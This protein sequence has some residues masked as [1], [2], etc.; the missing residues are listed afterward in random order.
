MITTSP[1]PADI[2][3]RPPAQ[4]MNLAAM[5]ASHATRLSFMRILLRRL[6]REKWRFERRVFDI[7]ARGVGTAVYVA[8]GPQCSYSLVCFGHDLP[9]EMRSDRVI[10]TAW[11]ATF[12]LHDGIA[13][14]QTIARLRDNIPL[15]EAG[16]VLA[17]EL[18]VSR[19]NRSVRL[20]EHVV[21]SLASGRQPNGSRVTETGYLMRTTAVYG[22]GKL[23]AADRESIAE[24]PEFNAPFQ[25]EMLSVYL[26]RA[27][28]ADLV[29]QM[30]RLRSPKTAVPLEPGLR[31]SLGVGNS[32]GLGMAPFLV[33]HP[34]LLNNWISAREHALARVRNLPAASAA[35][36]ARFLDLLRSSRT[37]ALQWHS[38]DPRQMQC[39]EGLNRDLGSLN[40]DLALSML[41]GPRPWNKLYGWAEQHL[42]PEGRELIAA[43]L[44]EPHGEIVDELADT[45][46]AD[47]STA[48][49]IDG[50]MSVGRMLELLAEIHGARIDMDWSDPKAIA[51]LWYVSAEKLEP[52]LGE[53]FEEPLDAYEQPLAPARDAAMMAQD[54]AMHDAEMRLAEFLLKH[55]RYRHVARRAQLASRLPYAEIRDNT[56][57][58]TMLPV[59]LLRCKLS[60]FGAQQFDPRSDRWI[61]INMFKGAP[62][63]HELETADADFW[64]Y[65]VL[66]ASA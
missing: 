54:L 14:E 7:D 13:D 35:Q 40:D 30:A 62:Y 49:R 5:G 23:G 9:P 33:N 27:F 20:F 28:I 25:V 16:R 52:R 2:A 37:N 18:S 36:V 32:T 60:F 46:S 1:E 10:A 11:D 51:R 59:D 48:F 17:S 4:V 66:P 63:P 47:E 55:P 64:P 19:A 53:R 50:S 29:E 15:Q 38:S 65:A 31:R 42:S 39:I 24:R 45:M 6:K 21:E 22:S 43:L 44:I 26:T 12:A 61:R 57:S 3:P 34:A 8:H 41:S 58:A 56:I